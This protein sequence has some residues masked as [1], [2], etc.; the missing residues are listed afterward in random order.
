MK[1][2]EM[3]L[4]T[5]MNFN[6]AKSSNFILLKSNTQ[7]NPCLF[8]NLFFLWLVI[9]TEFKQ[10][11]N[12]VQFSLKLGHF[13]SYPS[14]N[15]LITQ[16]PQQL[17]DN[18]NL[19]LN[20]FIRPCL[21]GTKAWTLPQKQYHWWIIC[22]YV[23][24]RRIWAQHK[25]TSYIREIYMNLLQSCFIVKQ[26]RVNYFSRIYLLDGY[27]LG[28]LFTPLCNELCTFLLPFQE[29]AIEDK[30]LQMIDRGRGHVQLWYLVDNVL[31][32]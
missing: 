27:S 31:Y 12:Y 14:I 16:S 7:I 21:K 28:V 6:T 20:S 30:S 15:K 13:F 9:C 32:N 22:L 2:N 1:L 24:D 8:T 18:W 19:L 23:L 17:P 11:N 5:T 26:G 10:S 29:V 3:T 4:P 25:N